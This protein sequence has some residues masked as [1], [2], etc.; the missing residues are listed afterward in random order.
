MSLSLSFPICD[1]RGA[2]YHNPWDLFQLDPARLQSRERCW[3]GRPLGAQELFSTA[4]LGA[5]EEAPPTNPES[6]AELLQTWS[7]KTVALQPSTFPCR[8]ADLSR[9]KS[10]NTQH[11]RK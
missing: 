6:A 4:V 5:E 1:E 2:G 8:R 9:E 11:T 10:Q 7:T 3:K